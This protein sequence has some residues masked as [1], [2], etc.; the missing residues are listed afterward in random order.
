MSLCLPLALFLQFFQ[1]LPRLPVL[2]SLKYAQ[3]LQ[4]PLPDRFNKFPSC[5]HLSHYSTVQY[6]TVQYSTV[7]YSTVQY[8]TVQYSTVQY[9]TVQ[10]ST[11]QYSTVQYST[12]QYSTVQYS[13]VQYSTVQ[14]LPELQYMNCH[15]A[16]VLFNGLF[17]FL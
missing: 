14:Y 8:S 1:L 17:C 10:Y 5:S 11:V 13:T 7:Q 15:T 2:L 12:V 9:S 3:K 4:L 6:S 16:L